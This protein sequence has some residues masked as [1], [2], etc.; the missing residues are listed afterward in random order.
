MARANS[1]FFQKLKLP[2]IF[3]KGTVPAA[4]ACPSYAYLY[5]F[6]FPAIGL[7]YLS[8]TPFSGENP[9]VFRIITIIFQSR[10]DIRNK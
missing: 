5:R 2:C 8:G 6:V 10:K 3:L 4:L 9:L 1:F 7:S